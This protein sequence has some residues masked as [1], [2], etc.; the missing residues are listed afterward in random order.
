MNV[1]FEDINACLVVYYS[2]GHI[3][4]ETICFIAN[5]TNN[6]ISV[7][8][9]HSFNRRFKLLCIIQHPDVFPQAVPKPWRSIRKRSSTR[10]GVEIKLV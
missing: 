10:F 2:S 6:V 8:E 9:K 4:N 5:C 3:L 1:K 7:F